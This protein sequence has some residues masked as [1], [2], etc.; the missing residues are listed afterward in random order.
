MNILVV[1]RLRGICSSGLAGLLVHCLLFA[2][3][4]LAFAADA[5]SP[6]EPGRDYH[7][8]ANIEEFRV[9]HLDLELQV[10]FEQQILSGVAEL[11]VERLV[12]GKR[13]LRLDTRDLTIRNVWW[14]ADSGEVLP[15]G[16]L[17][18]EY[19]RALGTPLLIELPAELDAAEFKLR[20]SY[21]TR[22]EASGLQWVPAAQTAGKT[23]PYLYTQSQAINARSWVP[24]QDSPQVRFTYNAVIR[25]PASLRAVMSASNALDLAPDGVYQFAMPQAIPSYLLALG[26][27][28][29]EFQAI[30]PRTGV[31]AEPPVLAAAA[32]EFADVEKML[33]TSEQ[34]F[35][36]YRWGRYD[37]LI[38]PPSF[39]F[40]GMENPRLSFI[41][42]TVLAG[43]R[44]LVSLI[45]HELAHS[46]SGN[47][48]TNATWR[49]LWLNEGFTVFLERR[50]VQA[51]YG[52]RRHDMED[53][54]GLQDLR[55]D[56]ADLPPAD[57]RLAIDLRGRD[58]DDVF[59]NVP[60]DKGRLFLGWLESRF[61][62][63]QFD[64]F[65]RGYFDHF[66]F[67]SISTEQF[68]VW[69]TDN[70]TAKQPGLVTDAE[71]DEWIYQPGLPKFAV[72]PQSPAFVAIDGARSDWLAGKR[73]VES[74]RGKDWTTHE[75]LHFLN[76][77]PARTPAVKL[78][79]LDQAFGLTAIGNNEIA[80]S[81]L[82]IAI[83]NNYEPAYERLANYLE[84]IGR[85]KLIKPLYEDLMKTPAGAARAAA[86]Y[87]KARG[88]YHPIAA[89][90]LDPIVY[91]R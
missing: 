56:M 50:I 67:Q 83:R 63:A 68:R 54:L 17:K 40:G 84:T 79:E 38:L 31:F 51:L 78:T 45:A 35:G 23:D 3:S 33:E 13:E 18:G 89:T 25:V 73:T 90:T 24:L 14:L 36:P 59:S 20:I 74:L 11:S 87:A 53:T 10:L 44:S 65:L 27:G 62:R 6:I 41:T 21:Q 69:L 81:W 30:G 86:I 72:L 43:D 77:F 28:K 55:D 22:P 39:P 19:D 91:G 32:A 52:E 29:L 15:L 61:G 80:H 47:L 8:L 60:Y 12:A 76:K 16:F 48:V 42:P 85:R 88:N 7:T 9:R 4:G 1:R 46:W 82:R 5:E 57:T 71:I 34:L 58:P 26:V 64:E 2:P 70:L 66:A 37:L 75:W 49:D